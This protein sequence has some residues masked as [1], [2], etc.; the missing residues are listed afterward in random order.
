MRSTWRGGGGSINVLDASDG[1]AEIRRRQRRKVLEN[2]GARGGR[3]DLE[4][5]RVVQPAGGLKIDQWK[6]AGENGPPP[7]TSR[8]FRQPA[9]NSENRIAATR[10]PNPSFVPEEV[11]PKSWPDR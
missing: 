9:E 5:N 2:L 11:A 8:P 6:A 3:E 4:R 10:S 7:F 1:F